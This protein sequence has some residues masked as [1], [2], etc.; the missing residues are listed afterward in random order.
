LL[1]IEK[2]S[3]KKTDNNNLPKVWDTLPRF[4][5][6]KTYDEPDKR[7]AFTVL[8]GAT[9][10]GKTTATLNI[11]KDT[12]H[13]YDRIFLFT[14]NKDNANAFEEILKVPP[15]N[16]FGDLA[17]PT[18]DTALRK[19]CKFQDKTAGHQKKLMLCFDDCID[20]KGKTSRSSGFFDWLVINRRHF[21]IS[22]LFSTQRWSKLSTT[23]RENAD[24]C[25]FFYN[26]NES[27]VHFLYK[28]F[29]KLRGWVE[30]DAREVLQK[31][32]N[33]KEHSVFVVLNTQLENK[34]HQFFPKKIDFSEVYKN[35]NAKTE[36]TAKQLATNVQIT[37]NIQNP[38][39]QNF[40][41][42][43]DPLQQYKQYRT[44]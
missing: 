28:N 8:F 12:Q 19:I 9:R 44:Q 5:I 11:L 27:A 33:P 38:M 25:L 18:T 2:S 16:I 6:K 10:S 34:Y 26:E 21:S 1:S 36:Q 42:E 3:G 41:L 4:D 13:L 43:M 29:L 32:S 15:N 24:V 40:Q 31:F 39:S 22:M 23:A 17:D 14:S 20:E 7:Y 35:K 30:D 37:Q